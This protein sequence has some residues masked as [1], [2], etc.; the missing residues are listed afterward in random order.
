MDNLNKFFGSKTRIVRNGSGAY[1][2]RASKSD[3]GTFHN[4][5]EI[6]QRKEVFSL[7]PQFNPFLR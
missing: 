7:H 1:V 2:Y 5:K 3:L 4:G 6:Q